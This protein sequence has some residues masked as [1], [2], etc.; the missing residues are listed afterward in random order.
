MES[1]ISLVE[2]TCIL[3]PDENDDSMYTDNI[4]PTKVWH[5]P[6]GGKLG[7]G[8]TIITSGNKHIHGLLQGNSFMN[9]ITKTDN[10][11]E[12]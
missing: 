11:I 12:I 2:C 7:Y 3:W 8:F 5:I 6:A 9:G 10:M 4:L 1:N